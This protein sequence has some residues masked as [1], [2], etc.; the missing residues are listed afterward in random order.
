MDRRWRAIAIAGGTVA[1]V[2]IVAALLTLGG[3]DPNDAA[4]ATTAS[5]TSAASTTAARSVATTAAP[6]TTVPGDQRAVAIVDEWAAATSKRDWASAARIDNSGTIKDYDQW[7]GRLDEP[8]HMERVDLFVDRT[9]PYGTSWLVKG[10]VM[11]GDDSASSGPST[12]VV[13]SY[14]V[15]DLQG[16][17]AAWNKVDAHRVRPPIDPLSYEDAYARYCS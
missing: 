4:T 6:T 1:I 16:H 10:A 12:N 8:S 9:A 15:V 2:G 13:C 14:W 3:G 7:Y 11:T 17:T 5:P